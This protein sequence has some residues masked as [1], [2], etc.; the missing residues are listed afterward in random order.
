MSSDSRI[1]R[2]V[3]RFLEPGDTLSQRTVRS[4]AWM[5][6]FRGVERLVGLVQIVILA[7]VLSPAD[8]GTV[9]VAMLAIAALD[10]VSQTG[11]D[12]AL[13]QKKDDIRGYLDTAWSLQVARGVLTFAVMMISAPWVA[14]FFHSPEATAIIRAVAFVPLLRGFA[15]SGVIYF[16]KDLDFR[17]HVTYE[18]AGTITNAV[19]SIT[20]ALAW[21]SVWALAL[22]LVAA[23]VARGVAS[24]RLH[25]FRPR[26]HIDWRKAGE[27]FRFGQWI[28]ANNAVSFVMLNGDNA[29]LGKLLGTTALGLYQVAFKVSNLAMTEITRVLSRVTLPAFS[30]LQDRPE[31]LRP[32]FLKSLDLVIFVSAPLSA[33]VIFFGPDF[34]RIFLGDKWTPM[35]TALKILA[36]SGLIRAVV[37]TGTS[38]YLSLYRPHLEFITTLVSMAGM[39][40]AVF[41]MTSRWGLTGTATAVLLGNAIVLPFWVVNYIRLVRGPVGPLLGRF[42]LL[43]LSF[44]VIGLPALGLAGMEPVGVI[45]FGI[46]VLGALVCYAALSW[47]LLKYFGRGPFQLTKE[48]IAS[49]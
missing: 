46:M 14:S 47:V 27:V 32:A 3:R 17:R 20:L 26:F 28:M 21:R 29:V 24:Y 11:F 31:R 9:G 43:A 23:H 22:G 49:M 18:V 8:F 41:P 44:G 12:V 5:L 48:I 33:G 45:G 4:G 15:N 39:A 1:Q 2:R 19:V 30:K 35:T 42:A 10:A 7:R 16:Q 25:P 37:A 40:I 13:I 36:V 6:G 38:L 34:V